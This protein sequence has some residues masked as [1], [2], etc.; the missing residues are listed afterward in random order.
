MEL[1]AA[2]TTIE[3]EE[4]DILSHPKRAI[5]DGIRM[6]PALRIGEQ[7]IS[8]IFLTREKITDFIENNRTSPTDSAF[9]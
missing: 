7:M 5:N 8:S 1:Q 3:V 2:D 9:S 4:I 6:I